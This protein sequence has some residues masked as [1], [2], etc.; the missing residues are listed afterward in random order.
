MKAIERFE[1]WHVFV[2]F[3]ALCFCLAL[4]LGSIDDLFQETRGVTTAWWRP[5]VHL[6]FGVAG[7]AFLIRELLLQFSR[8]RGRL[9]SGNQ[10]RSN[11]AVEGT[12]K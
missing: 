6:G 8:L 10:D 2:T 1:P 4:V 5:I 11:H 12:A 7:S 9:R 3:Y